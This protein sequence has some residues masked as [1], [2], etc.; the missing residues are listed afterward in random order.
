MKYVY[1]D[2]SICITLSKTSKICGLQES[3][4]QITQ[5]YCHNPEVDN[6]LGKTSQRLNKEISNK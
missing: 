1:E 3:L 6:K 5:F 4:L 2:F